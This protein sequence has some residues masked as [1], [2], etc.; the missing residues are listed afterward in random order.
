MPALNE[1]AVP[2]NPKEE[3]SVPEGFLDQ[4]GLCV[5]PSFYMPETESLRWCTHNNIR[6]TL[7]Y[8]Q[9][10]NLKYCEFKRLRNEAD[11]FV[12]DK[13]ELCEE[14]VIDKFIEQYW[15]K[16]KETGKLV[17]TTMWSVRRE[18]AG[19]PDSF[20]RYRTKVYHMDD[21]EF[22][23]K[24]YPQSPIDTVRYLWFNRRYFRIL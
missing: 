15:S 21:D 14:G 23:V 11:S 9:F 5:L 4:P 18:R 13:V 19:A 10:R 3:K 17:E 20:G 22:R 24:M 2:E 6:K 1:S 8:Q 16:E 7:F 12:L